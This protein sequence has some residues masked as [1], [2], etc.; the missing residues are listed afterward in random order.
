MKNDDWTLARLIAQRK[1]DRSF[2]RL[3]IDCGGIPTANRLQQ[4]AT[5]DI[6]AFPDPETI[7]GMSL[8]LG[9]TITEVTLAIARSLGLNVASGEPDALT[10]AGAGAL[11]VEAQEAII[12]VSREMQ[13]LYSPP[14]RLSLVN[15]ERQVEDDTFTDRAAFNADAR[16]EVFDAQ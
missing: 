15:K 1:G 8:G 13:R 7:R 5:K 14:K 3:S 11:P 4:M 10:L 2:K 6:N 9:T 12:T 16:G